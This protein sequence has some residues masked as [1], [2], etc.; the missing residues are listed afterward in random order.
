MDKKEL[1]E[2]AENMAVG[3]CNI[4]G[5]IVNGQNSN[6]KYIVLAKE[7]NY[8]DFV[9]IFYE[10]RYDGE[11]E[12]GVACGVMGVNNMADGSS[13]HVEYSNVKVC[14]SN[15]TYNLTALDAYRAFQY[16]M[17]RDIGILWHASGWNELLE[18]VSS[19]LI[20]SIDQI[21]SNLWSYHEDEMKERGYTGTDVDLVSYEAF[22]AKALT[23]IARDI[24]D[25]DLPADNAWYKYKRDRLSEDLDEAIDFAEK[26]C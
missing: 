21:Q 10:E 23:A 3:N 15:G 1:R 4:F 12:Y 5:E 18:A 16:R 13:D 11:K 2:K 17:D 24:I 8:S 22:K 9:A 14:H 25:G 19:H 7:K 6:I 26:F 20:V